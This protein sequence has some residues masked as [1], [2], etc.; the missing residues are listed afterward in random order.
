MR[1]IPIGLYGCRLARRCGL[2][3]GGVSLE[4]GFEVSKDPCIPTVPS[5]SCLQFEM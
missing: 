3:G 2:V 1:V 5:A 4:V